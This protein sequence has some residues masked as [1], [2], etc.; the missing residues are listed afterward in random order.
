MKNIDEA[1]FINTAMMGAKDYYDSGSSEYANAIVYMY[2]V[3]ERYKYSLFTDGLKYEFDNV[4]K[5]LHNRWRY[6]FGYDTQ[7]AKTNVNN[8]IEVAEEMLVKK[9]RNKRILMLSHKVKSLLSDSKLTDLERARIM[10][11]LHHAG[12]TTKYMSELRNDIISRSTDASVLWILT[13][14]G[15]FFKE[16]FN[17][18][19]WA[20]L[21]YDKEGYEE[22]GQEASILEDV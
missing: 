18:K 3:G 6:L 21:L 22:E 10:A 13:G 8:P 12:I 5:S 1:V 11:L 20:W 16:P 4:N 2:F 17:R 7:L 9:R 19:Y 14:D 15:R